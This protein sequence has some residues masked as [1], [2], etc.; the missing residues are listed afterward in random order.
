M[1]MCHL[2]LIVEVLVSF[3]HLVLK[4][5]LLGLMWVHELQLVK[6]HP[7]LPSLRQDQETA[8]ETFAKWTQV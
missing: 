5:L 8:T 4:L 6:W 3:T 1:M 2:T 7:N